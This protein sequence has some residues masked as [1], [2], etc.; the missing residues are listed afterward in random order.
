MS[1]VADVIGPEELSTFGESDEE[2]V[3]L[4]PEEWQRVRSTVL[5]LQQTDEEIECLSRGL[6]L[7]NDGC[8]DLEREVARLRAGMAVVAQAWR[9]RLED[10]ESITLT[11][12]QEDA[13]PLRSALE[14][15]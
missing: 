3:R 14:V 1:D 13:A 12:I 10:R 15:A 9:A 11:V 5:F 6:A 8:L 7:M 4:T 2:G